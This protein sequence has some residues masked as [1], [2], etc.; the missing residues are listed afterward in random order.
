MTAHPSPRHWSQIAGS[1]VRWGLIAFS[2]ARFIGAGLLPAMQGLRGDFAAV[3]PSATLAHLR[4]DFIASGWSGWFYGPMLHFITL[5]LFLVPRWALV[6]T[7]WALVNTGTLVLGFWLA[8]RIAVSKPPSVAA[9]GVVAVLWML[10]QPLTNCLA[11]GNIEIIEMVL[12]LGALA[13]MTRWKGR[14][15]GVLVGIAAMTKILP[16]GFL[17]WFALRRAWRPFIYGLATIVVI[18][19]VTAV[20]LEWKNSSTYRDLT[21]AVDTPIAGTQELS[22][23]SSFLHRASVLL[24]TGSAPG[25][26]PTPRWFP[27]QRESVASSAGLL[28][29]G[30]LAAGFAVALFLRRERASPRFQIAVLFMTM[31]M[32]L[33]WNHDYYFI[34]ALPPITV[35]FMDSFERVD[36][37]QLAVTVI[38]Y[39][40]ISPP[41]PFSWIDRAHVL[42]LNF[43]DLYGYWDLPILGALIIWGASAYRMLGDETGASAPARRAV[44]RPWGIATSAIAA[45]GIGATAISLVGGARDGAGTSRAVDT[46]ALDPA[47]AVSGPPALALS[48]DG[49]YLAYVALKDGIRVLCV[50]TLAQSTTRCLPKTDD[51]AVPFFSPDSQWIAFVSGRQL[52]KVPT[53]GSEVPKLISESR[54]ARTGRWETDGTILLGTPTNGIMR[55]A[56]SGGPMEVAVPQL[57]D[58]APYGWPALLPTGDVVLFTVPP[59]GGGLGFGW[60]TAYAFRTRE[61]TPLLQGS[62]PWF[63]A[64]RGRLYFTRSGRIFSV[65]FDSETLKT[66]GPLV[67]VSDN[68]LVTADAGP[69][70][71]YGGFGGVA[72]AS[73]DLLPVVRHRFVWVDRRGFEAALPVPPDGFQTPRLSP[74]GTQIVAS[75]RGVTTDLWSL[76]VSTGARRR[77]T[78]TAVAYETPV[79][80]RDGSIAFTAGPSGA[81]LVV[82]PGGTDARAAMLS[83]PVSPVQLGGWS[84]SGRILV[85]SQEGD[86]WMLDTTSLAAPL[87]P[88]GQ[89]DTSP[90]SPDRWRTIIVRTPWQELSP[91]VSPDGRFIAYSSNLTGRA[92]IYVQATLGLSDY[93]QVSLNGGTEPVW[94]RDGRE[95]FYRQG[96]LMMAI[97]TETI[98]GF[99]AGAPRVL[100]RGNYLRGD[101]TT[102]YDIAPDG[103]RFLMLRDDTNLFAGGTQIKLVGIPLASRTTLPKR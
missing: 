55:V 51:A 8:I 79:W 89:R 4:P 3:F 32:V 61:R 30:L 44:L 103:Q 5:P 75:I 96:D 94:S 66:S 88:S 48:P 87:L 7:V 69:V 63:D 76:D 85:G 31:F 9:S 64:V 22:I 58:E 62:Q 40:L 72:Y 12:V 1:V 60:I 24:E 74:D 93:R 17:F 92:E 80:M 19:A 2:T 57:P 71:A 49:K 81:V 27:S 78:S 16:I 97:P 67:P 90:T 70:V 14:A 13:A 26:G 21:W 41:I 11:Q 100:F 52:R 37:M 68:T 101:G 73:G 29:S 91:V 56:A 20:T 28:A 53:N 34:F 10:Y 99:S 102:S 84:P 95:L 82:P 50:R 23:T 86:L 43:A 83:A 38:G 25:A 47:L 65:A 15:S 98:S 45:V 39:V 33:P 35:L 6:P 59:K 18:A 36:R 77:V 46:L 54:G 42:P